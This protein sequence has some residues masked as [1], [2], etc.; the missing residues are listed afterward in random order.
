MNMHPT[1]APPV[2]LP[3]GCSP[4][5]RGVIIG[6]DTPAPSP[7]HPP[8]HLVHPRTLLV[9]LLA[10]CCGGLVHAALAPPL[11]HARRSAAGVPANA[12]QMRR[13][14]SV[15]AAPARRSITP[16]LPALPCPALPCP[17]ATLAC[18]PAPST[19][20][21][22]RVGPWRGRRAGMQHGRNRHAHMCAVSPPMVPGTADTI[23]PLRPVPL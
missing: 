2:T 15:A 21:E 22:Q 1:A 4:A 13:H 9:M 23:P 11:C 10:S 18:T 7:P 20:G 12:V 8:L 17:G 14:P 16:P 5:G 19:A 6:R 3:R